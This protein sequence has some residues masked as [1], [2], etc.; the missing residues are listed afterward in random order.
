MPAFHVEVP[1]ALGKD[2]ARERLKGFV[3]KVRELYKDQ[4]SAVEGEWTDDNLNFSMKSYG[5]SFTGKIVVQD[6]LVS[7]DGQLPFAA[8]AFRGKIEQ[9]FRA[10][11]TRALT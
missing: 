8:I 5:F 7:L 9:S 11:L 10:A 6:S 2:A 3:D 1:H 4:V